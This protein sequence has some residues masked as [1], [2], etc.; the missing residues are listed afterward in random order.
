MVI[1]E[2]V[3]GCHDILIW[4]KSLIKWGQHPDMTLAVD[5][6]VKHKL[7]QTI[8]SGNLVHNFFFQASRKEEN[9]RVSSIK[10]MIEINMKYYQLKCL[11]TFSPRSEPIVYSCSGKKSQHLQ[12]SQKPHLKPNQEVLGLNPISTPKNQ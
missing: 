8:L 9:F 3:F 11:A 12:T 4:G 6:N 1:F 5:W 7:K 2:A 10:S